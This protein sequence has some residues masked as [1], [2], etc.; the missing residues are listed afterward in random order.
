[1]ANSGW[2][3][4]SSIVIDELAQEGQVIDWRHR[5]ELGNEG[6]AYISQVA[7]PITKLWKLSDF[8]QASDGGYVLP[9]DYIGPC[10]ISLKGGSCFEWVPPEDFSQD[11]YGTY[12][13]TENKLYI[14]VSDSEVQDVRIRAYASLPEIT[15][16]TP[17]NDPLL[18]IPPIGTYLL[19]YYILMRFPASPDVP[20]ELARASKYAKMFMETLPIFEEA[21]RAR[22]SEAYSRN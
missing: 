8:T 7:R 16:D 17:V 10:S 2:P 5:I 9:A 18:M 21:C 3:V 15:S 1:M 11:D 13:I 19:A 22:E 20:R 4:T 6:L 14:A 12:T